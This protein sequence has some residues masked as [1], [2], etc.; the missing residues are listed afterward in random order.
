[1]LYKSLSLT[2]HCRRR[3]D[4][5]KTNGCDWTDTETVYT[6]YAG[7]TTLF[8]ITRLRKS[9]GLTE[10]DGHENDGPNLHGIK[11]LL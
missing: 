3:L 8:T 10:N 6:L 9:Q 7:K 4:Q 5:W 2:T 1:M 11:L